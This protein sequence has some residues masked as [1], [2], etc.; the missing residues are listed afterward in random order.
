[1]SGRVSSTQTMLSSAEV[2]CVVDYAQNCKIGLFD[3]AKTECL[4]RLEIM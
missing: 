1:M 3:G 2:I 4:S